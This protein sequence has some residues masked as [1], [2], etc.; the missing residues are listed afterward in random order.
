ML[1]YITISLTVLLFLLTV[2]PMTR[3]QVW[4][5]RD[6]DFP[7]L[8]FAT[9]G[10]IGFALSL[11]L[12]DRFLRLGAVL[13]AINAACLAYQ[14]W[15]I[16]PFTRIFPK[17]VRSS[18]SP[19][20]RNRLR[21]VVANVL[22]TNRNAAGLLRIVRQEDPDILVTLETDAWWE[23]QLAELEQH[24]PSRM[25]CP[26]SNLYG[27]HLYSRLPLSDSQICFLV[28]KDRPSMHAL[29]TLRSGQKIA[30]H[31]LH[32]SPPSPTENDAS[33]ER[34]AELLIVGKRVARSRLPV[35]VT[36][37]MNDVAW[38]A[39]TRLFRKISGLLDPRIGRG[40]FNT[41]HAKH[42]L[43]RWPLDHL[44]HSCH[45][46]LTRMKRLPAFG[47]DHFPIMVELAF[48]PGTGAQQHGLVADEEDRVWADE[49]TSAASAHSAD[50]PTPGE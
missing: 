28:E 46:T 39:T 11:S 40:M 31:C 37:D 5:I 32:P 30:L 36:G 3:W 19:D 42:F 47:S 18:R 9:L 33:T 29:V 34:D 13:A 50:V 44:F 15:W 12:L 45:F 17:E 1:L 23:E 6:G 22:M 26:L 24:Y 41:F 10:L 14:L 27:M 38:S 16:M 7:R 21:V 35:V 4:W 49:K 8:A 20:I 43:V 48:E 2:L 25:R